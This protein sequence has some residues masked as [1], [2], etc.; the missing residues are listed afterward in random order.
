MTPSQLPESITFL[1]GPPARPDER[2]NFNRYQAELGRPAEERDQAFCSFYEKL[3]DGYLSSLVKGN[4][5]DGSPSLIEQLFEMVLRTPIRIRGH[6]VG[7][8]F[9][10]RLWIRNLHFQWDDLLTPTGP[11]PALSGD[12]V[13]DLA[14]AIGYALKLDWVLAQQAYPDPVSAPVPRVRGHRARPGSGGK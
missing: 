13:K 9:Y 5:A 10:R 7:F 12:D 2:A 14:A 3:M 11:L 6:F 8:G 4:C 1:L